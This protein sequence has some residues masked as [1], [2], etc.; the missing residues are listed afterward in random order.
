MKNKRIVAILLALSLMLSMLSACGSSSSNK[1]S[2][3]ASDNGASV[4]DNEAADTDADTDEN[5]DDVIDSDEQA[6]NPIVIKFVSSLAQTSVHGQAYEAFKAAVEE[7]TNGAIQIDLYHSGTLMGDED[8]LEGVTSGAVGL[9][10]ITAS[11]CSNEIVDLVP[12]AL[13]GSGQPIIPNDD[14]DYFEKY[15]DATSD[16]LSAIFEE[17]GVHYFGGIPMGSQCFVG[18]IPVYSADDLDGKLVRASGTWLAKEISG[19]GAAAM[20]IAIGDVAISLERGTID[21]VY[22]AWSACDSFRFYESSKYLTIF[23]VSEAAGATVINLDVWNSLTEEQQEIMTECYNEVLVGKINEGLTEE[24]DQLIVNA[25]E[26]GCEV[27]VL[28]QEATESFY[29]VVYDVLEE[30][31]AT[32]GMTDNG[33]ALADALSGLLG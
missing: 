9:A 4:S 18:E 24:Y 12:W 32:S 25:Q 13:V 27:I 8:M 21:L 28:D 11:A 7:R 26:A 16:I 19:W 29:P 31:K 22:T 3:S 33:F 20:T 2:A 30:A 23:G 14:P 6:A 1:E 5:A 17:R 10:A 15:N